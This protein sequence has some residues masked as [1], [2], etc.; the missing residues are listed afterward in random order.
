MNIALHLLPGAQPR[1]R[2][3][4]H[5]LILKIDETCDKELFCSPVLLTGTGEPSGKISGSISNGTVLYSGGASLIIRLMI[6]MYDT[7][8]KL[9]KAT[10]SNKVHRLISFLIWAPRSS[11]LSDWKCRVKTIIPRLRCV[12]V[13]VH[14]IHE[15]H[16]LALDDV[17]DNEPGPEAAASSVYTDSHEPRELV[18]VRTAAVREGHCHKTADI[19]LWKTTN[20]FK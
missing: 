14:L 3:Q 5:N 19:E 16:P 11:W 13:P 15:L 4:F 17:A 8:N 12:P 20:P 2:I 10:S 7:H 6:M 18:G 9:V 1:P